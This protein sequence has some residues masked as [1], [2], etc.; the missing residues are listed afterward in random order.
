MDKVHFSSKSILWETPQ[1][2][3]DVLNKKYHFTID[4]CA[5]KE[6]TKCTKFY[7]PE[8][9]GLQQNWKGICWMNPPYGRDY[10]FKWVQKAYAK[11][12]KDNCT[13]V[14]LLPAGT[15]TRWFHEFIYNRQGVKVTFIKGRLKFGD[16]INSAPFPSMLV[17]FKQ[18]L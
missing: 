9:D 7:S 4:V 5:T 17:V 14:S 2:F 13:V 6:N 18:Q 8:I 3:F 16:S 15:D 1:S 11:S 12:R 10:T